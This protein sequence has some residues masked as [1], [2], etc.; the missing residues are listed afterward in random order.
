MKNRICVSR[1]TKRKGGGTLRAGEREENRDCSGEFRRA[2]QAGEA[3]VVERG[4][5]DAGKEAFLVAKE[6]CY[7][8]RLSAYGEGRR[9]TARRS[10]ARTGTAS[11]GREK[12]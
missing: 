12:M 1:G 7:L 10:D 4:G 6:R 11:W 8:L 3:C 2:L 5:G 9:S